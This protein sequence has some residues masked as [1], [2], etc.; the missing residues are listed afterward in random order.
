M[1]CGLLHASLLTLAT[2]SPV[3]DLPKV[4]KLYQ[5]HACDLNRQGEST[6]DRF[7]RRLGYNRVVVPQSP[8]TVFHVPSVL[9]VP[10][11][12]LVGSGKLTGNRTGTCPTRK[13]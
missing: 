6:Y 5:N 2:F 13:A 9:F 10:Y 11:D 8:T 3:L 7:A 4:M 1:R 12:I